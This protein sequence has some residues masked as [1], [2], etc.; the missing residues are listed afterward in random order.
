MMRTAPP[1]FRISADQTL[2]A[3]A[4]RGVFGIAI[5]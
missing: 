5:T 4:L 1:A 2:I 3:L